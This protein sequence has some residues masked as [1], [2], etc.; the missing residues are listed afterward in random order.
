MNLLRKNLFR[1]LVLVASL[2]IADRAFA[3]DGVGVRMG[4]LD[5]TLR[6]TKLVLPFIKSGAVAATAT[7]T[8]ANA[9][10][11]GI[12]GNLVFAPHSTGSAVGWSHTLTTSIAPM[13][14]P[15]RV[16]F[17]LYPLG[18]ISATNQLGCKKLEVDGLDQFGREVGLSGDGKPRYKFGP[19]IS[20]SPHTSSIAFSKITRIRLE[21]CFSGT[22]CTN[23]GYTCSTAPANGSQFRA[24]MTRHVGLPF[25]VRSLADIQ[26][27][28]ISS[29]G[30]GSTCF[31]NDAVTRA[32]SGS[33]AQGSFLTFNASRNTLSFPNI[34]AASGLATRRT[35]ISLPVSDTNG[36]TNL[37]L[38]DRF[39][40]TIT[41]KADIRNE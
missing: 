23:P 29:A 36:Q 16:V 1:I 35:V 40:Y 6:T 7:I 33:D 41:Y 27:V 38:T 14:Y 28:C 4:N 10:A 37:L 13:A 34:S 31:R 18:G 30:S 15:A 24:I 32:V 21:G 26:S 5:G 2:G 17:A 39:Q 25:R 22:S 8:P 11:R 3:Q 12:Q 9:I 20:G 19:L